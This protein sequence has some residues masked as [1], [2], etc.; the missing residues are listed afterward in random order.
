MVVHDHLGDHRIIV[1]RNLATFLDPGINTH[2]LTLFGQA[3]NVERARRRQET[4]LRI[5]GIEPRLHG[6]SRQADL[7]L[8]RHAA[9]RGDVQLQLHEV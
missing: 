1:Q 8:G 3:Q 7:V 6:M 2:T 9:A 5:L 4:R